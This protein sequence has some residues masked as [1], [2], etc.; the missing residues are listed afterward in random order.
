MLENFGRSLRPRGGF[1]L[2]VEAD[3]D[4]E[5]DL[6]PG[7]DALAENL[8]DSYVRRCARSILVD[9]LPHAEPERA[10]RL[11]AIL[12]HWML[13][14][15]GAA[16]APL[17][18]RDVYELRVHQWLDRLAEAGLTVEHHAFTDDLPLFHLY[19]FR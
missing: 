9:D 12:R 15:L 14:Q 8:L 18:D 6:P 13:G 1:G 17:A 19:R 3:V 11:R 16:E 5:I 10:A 4:C 7:A 2:L